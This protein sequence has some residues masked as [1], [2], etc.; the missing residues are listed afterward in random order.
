[1]VF[2][3]CTVLF[4]QVP[5]KGYEVETK[6]QLIAK[7]WE[8]CRKYGVE[9]TCGYPSVVVTGK[10]LETLLAQ[11]RELIEAAQP[12]MRS[13]YELV[14]STGFVVVL[15]NSEGYIIE[16]IG[17]MNGAQSSWMRYYA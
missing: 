16:V 17:E 5:K 8:R 10:E 1:M 2:E 13:L 6:K 9:P 14:S 3:K 7:S 4:R 11:S 15:L 12:L